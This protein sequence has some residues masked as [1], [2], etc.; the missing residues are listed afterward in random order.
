MDKSEKVASYFDEEHRFKDSIAV[1]RNLV[2]K[3]GLDET[4]KWNFPTYTLNNK[5]V[6]SICKF[7]NH[8]GVWFFNG[9]FLKDEKKVLQNAQE[10][11]TQGMRHWKFTSIDDINEMIV[12]AY[13][14]EAVEN[15]K[16]GLTI[17]PKKTTKKSF[18][19]P[20]ML[21]ENINSDTKFKSAFDG[22][23]PSKQ[24]EY[25]EYIT[26][27]KQEK[28]KIARLHKIVPMIKEGIGLHDK[29]RNC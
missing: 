15:Q 25:C 18:V 13:M 8:F 6:L 2:L 16:K 1:L 17:T 27:A 10:G 24:K 5:N 29:Y 3:T 20:P 21:L 23:S 7:K 19:I 9:V 14:Q 28:T 26:E 4:Y 12:L 11:K 22:L